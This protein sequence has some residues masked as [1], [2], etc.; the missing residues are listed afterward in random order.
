MPKLVEKLVQ[1][2]LDGLRRAAEELAPAPQKQLQP[3]PVRAQKRPRHP[4]SR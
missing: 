3:I 4:L 1:R 2:L